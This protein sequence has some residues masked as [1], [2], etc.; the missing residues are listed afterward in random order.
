MAKHEVIRPTM[1]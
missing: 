1:T